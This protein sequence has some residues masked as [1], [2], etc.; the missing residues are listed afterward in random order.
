MKKYSFSKVFSLFKKFGGIRLLGAYVKL[1]VFFRVCIETIKGLL[2]LQSADKIYNRYQPY[3]VKAL[4]ARYYNFMLERLKENEKKNLERQKSDIVWWCWLQGFDNA[5]PIVKACY[6]SLKQNIKNKE[7]RIIDESNR[8]EYIQLPDYIEQRWKKRQIPPAMFSDLIRLEL[9]IKYG[10]TWIDSTVLSTG[11]DYPNEYLDAK[12]FLFQY[13]RK[14]SNHF[15]GISNWFIT[16]YSNHPVLMTLRDMLCAYYM[17]FNCVLEYFIFHRFIEMIFH[18]RPEIVKEMPYGFSPDCHIL[19]HHWTERFNQCK[20]NELTGR[21][22]FHKLAHQIDDSIY[23]DKN[24]YFNHIIE[25]LYNEQ[26][27]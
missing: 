5:P 10:G 22:Y 15:S 27:P 25:I 16:S 13:S 19:A 11:S 2:K 6:C 23:D 14:E 21:I 20:W 26:K 17:D 8:S 24:N 3:V 9:L 12:L 18:M 4:R 1:G 7:I